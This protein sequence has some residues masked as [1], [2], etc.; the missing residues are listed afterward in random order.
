MKRP[1]TLRVVLAALAVSV[2]T[3]GCADLSSVRDWSGSSLQGVQFASVVETYA[4][5]P[6]RLAHYD[7]DARDFHEQ[8]AELRAKQ[9]EALELQLALISDYM[10]A[11]NALAADDVT[12][13]SRDVRTLTKALEDTGVVSGPTVGAAGKLATTLL[14]AATNAWRRYQVTRLIE[15]ANDPLQ[16]LLGGELAS[17]VGEDFRRDLAI[18][19]QFLDRYFEDLLR[20]PEGDATGRAALNEWFILRKEENARRQAAI[21]AYLVILD[22]VAE[23]HQRLYDERNDL[24]AK[25]LAKDLFKLAKDIRRQLRKVLRA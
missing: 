2:A 10:A 12:E 19:R 7:A 14:E 20:D 22:K 8:Q 18:E 23:G 13:Y 25:A 24:A 21:D 6:K 1:S 4:D 5:T 15:Q 9:A 16:T 3:A 17:I 11:L